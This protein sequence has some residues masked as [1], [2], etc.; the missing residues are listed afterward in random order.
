MS[1][2]LESIP[3]RPLVK[4]DAVWAEEFFTP[5]F[6]PN[7]GYWA[8]D[9]YKF[10]SCHRCGINIRVRLIKKTAGTGTYD[11]NEH[12]EFCRDCNHPAFLRPFDKDFYGLMRKSFGKVEE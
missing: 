4:G 8:D 2:V 12:R 7:G 11:K 9:G 10:Q 3:G 6:L 5:P 1:T